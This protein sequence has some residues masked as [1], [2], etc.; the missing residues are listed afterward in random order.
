MKRAAVAL[1]WAF[2]AS[3]CAGSVAP[4]ANETAPSA[5]PVDAARAGSAA[6]RRAVRIRFF[7][8]SESSD[9]VWVLEGEPLSVI[10]KIPVGRFPH[11]LSV[12]PDGR[13]IAVAN[14]FAN[15][16]SIIDPR[17]MR[18]VARV[19]VGKQPHD[20]IWSPDAKTIF[21]GAERE[22]YIYR[23][24][25]DTWKSLSPLSV[26]V[27]QHTLA[28]WKDR[29]NELWFTV[30]NAPQTANALRVYDF[31][32]STVTAIAVSD[33][34]DVFFSPDGSE[35][36][37]SSSGYLCKPSDRMVVYDPLTK[38]VKQEIRFPGHYPFH[39]IKY[40]RDATFFIDQTDTMVLSDHQAEALLIVDWRERAIKATIPLKDPSLPLNPTNAKCGIQP[41]HTAYAPGRYYVT[42][43]AD[44]SVR[45][46]DAEEQRVLYRVE[47]P[48]PH[49]IVL[50]P[51]DQ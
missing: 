17:T 19:M 25:A 42:S 15:S 8:A 41:F 32:S 4:I 47:V 43:N 27:P 34:H 7:V 50:V 6:A 26:Q 35:V 45:V 3:G 44:N 46:V 28:I 40:D 10:A 16:A 5:S 14:R 39:T 29:P 24:E 23:I 31:T 36:W 38:K 33:V 9:Q 48:T 30:T 20:I 1:A 11:N 51:L 12:S 18:E 49:G 21:V 22:A 2:L 13:W 37:S